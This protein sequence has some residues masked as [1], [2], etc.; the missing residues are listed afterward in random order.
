M[1]C[2]WP[3]RAFAGYSGTTGIVGAG[4]SATGAPMVLSIMLG[5]IASVE[6]IV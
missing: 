4:R 6:V 2:V 1:S 3:C 5:R